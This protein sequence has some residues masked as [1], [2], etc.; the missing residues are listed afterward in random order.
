MEIDPRLEELKRKIIILLT[1]GFVSAVGYWLS[2]FSFISVTATDILPNESFQYQI[3]SGK[4]LSTTTSKSSSLKKLV[5]K[6]SYVV[7]VKQG[8]KNAFSSASTNGLFRTTQLELKLG[9]EKQV[10]FIGDNPLTCMQYRNVLFSYLCNG[11]AEKVQAHIPANEKSASKIQKLNMDSVFG[12]RIVGDVQ[13][14]GTPYLF[15]VLELDGGTELSLIELGS[16]PGQATSGTVVRL[17]NEFP[18]G[19][20]GFIIEAFRSGFLVYSPTGK[21]AMFYDAI[22]DQ[23]PENIELPESNDNSLSNVYSFDFR[24]DKTLATITNV[25]V[26]EAPNVAYKPSVPNISPEEI[27]DE[28][29]FEDEDSHEGKAR[30]I[31][32]GLSFS[33]EINLNRIPDQVRFCGDSMVCVLIQGELEIYDIKQDTPKLLAKLPGVTQIEPLEDR[34]LLVLSG[35]VAEYNTATLQGYYHYYFGEYAYCGLTVHS[36]QL[37]VCVE[38]ELNESRVSSVLTLDTTQNKLDDIDK[39]VLKISKLSQIKSLAVY[40]NL[41]HVSADYGELTTNPLTGDLGYSSSVIKSVNE[42]ILKEIQEAGI[43]AAKYK[44][45]NPIR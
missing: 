6:G 45:I 21:V 3:S 23:D 42:T 37:L 15:G 7:S 27:H 36:G 40:N 35:G 10:S 8:T 13:L 5:R 22:F 18:A 39:Q 33:T 44:V 29:V 30:V 17:P 20:D 1:F 34:L 28:E 25:N 9:S 11:S 2:G 4:D 32:K 31:V 26:V 41:I 12:Y 16:T 43:D 19:T 14:G 24:D 38:N